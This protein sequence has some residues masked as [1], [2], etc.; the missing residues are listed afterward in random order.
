M[1]RIR[2][3]TKAKPWARS[4]PSRRSSSGWLGQRLTTSV[5]SAA[6]HQLDG[7][8]VGILDDADPQPGAQL[9]DG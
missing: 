9:G 2:G 5:S 7:V 4:Q 6:L 3:R 8:A 1:S